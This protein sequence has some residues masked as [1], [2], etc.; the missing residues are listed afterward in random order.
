MTTIKRRSFGAALAALGCSWFGKEVQASAE[1]P[2]TAL[3]PLTDDLLGRMRARGWR[4]ID[5]AINDERGLSVGYYASQKGADEMVLVS[6]RSGTPEQ[7]RRGVEYALAHM[8]D[9]KALARR[10]PEV[11]RGVRERKFL[12][13]GQTIRVTLV[14]D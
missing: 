10:E 3:H 6:H 8:D 5:Q 2:M 11:I 1:K 9:L 12:I 4:D 13:Y 14:R 7:V